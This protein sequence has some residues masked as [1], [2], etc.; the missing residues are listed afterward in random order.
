MSHSSILPQMNLPQLTGELESNKAAQ[1]VNLILWHGEQLDRTALQ[2]YFLQFQTRIYFAN[3]HNLYK[4]AVKE[5][6]RTE[7]A[8]RQYMKD[9]Y[10]QRGMPPHE[11]RGGGGKRATCIVTEWFVDIHSSASRLR[12]DRDQWKNKIENWRKKGETWFEIVEQFGL[13]ILLLV[14]PGEADSQ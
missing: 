2:S 13:G 9:W 5:V 12:L 1:F 11:F 3:Y 8:F 4:A 6:G 7:S 14:P 10:R